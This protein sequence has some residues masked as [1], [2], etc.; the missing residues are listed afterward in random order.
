MVTEECEHARDRPGG[1]PLHPPRGARGPRLERHAAQGPPGPARRTSSTWPLHPGAG[2]GRASSTSCSTTGEGHSGEPFVL[3]LLDVEACGACTVRREPVGARG[4]PVGVR[5]APGR[6]A[7]GG[8]PGT[9]KRRRDRGEQGLRA[10]RPPKA[11]KSHVGGSPRRRRTSTVG[12]EPRSS[13]PRGWAGRGAADD[14]TL[15]RA[16]DDRRSTTRGASGPIARLPGGSGVAR[17]LAAL[18]RSDGR[19][20]CG[21][22]STL[23]PPSGGSV[24]LGEVTVAVLERY[25]RFLYRYRKPNGRPLSFR[26]QRDRLRSRC[27][28][29]SWLP[30]RQRAPR[31]RPSSL[32]APRAEK[33]LP[34]GVLTRRGGRAGARPA[35]EATPRACA[36]GRSSRS[37]TPPASA[38]RS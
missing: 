36:T 31:T 2:R 1:L 17:L 14:A 35:G 30:V 26:T 29:S 7:V 9:V 25:Q 24:R 6:G 4:Q 27:G 8:W 28:A 32:R 10:E 12:G 33:R 15:P 3:G 34:R 19:R 16:A 11:R 13:E 5:S 38:A 37:S 23:V 18:G 22:S 21:S 20:A